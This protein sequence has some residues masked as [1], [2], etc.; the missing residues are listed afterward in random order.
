MT[1]ATLPATNSDFK[2]A[3][4][5]LQSKDIIGSLERE[6]S[7]GLES[8]S[9][10]DKPQGSFAPSL[11]IALSPPST[12]CNSVDHESSTTSIVTLND[13]LSH[14]L[15]KPSSQLSVSPKI[16]STKQL[17]LH[18]QLSSPTLS[19]SDSCSKSI[20]ATPCGL[21]GTYSNGYTGCFEGP[22]KLLEIWFDQKLLPPTSF[23]LRSIPRPELEAMLSLVHCSILD[24]F[25][26]DHL[27]SY[28]LSESSMFVFPSKIILKT[29]GTTTLLLALTQILTLANKYCGFHSIS[30]IFYSRKSFMF[31]DKQP[32]PHNSWANEV[33][34]L[35]SYFDGGKAYIIGDLSSEYWHLYVA[36]APTL[37]GLILN[38]SFQ[39]DHLSTPITLNSTPSSLSNISF[40]SAHS[41][42]TD[43]TVEILMTGLDQQKMKLMYCHYI[44]GAQEGLEGGKIVADECGLSSIYPGATASS[45]LFSPCG[46]SSNGLQ[47][48]NYF[49]VH[50][51]P[52]PSCSYASFESNIPLASISNNNSNTSTQVAL[53]QLVNQVIDIFLPKC[54]T[55]TVFYTANLLEQN[56]VP[57]SDQNNPDICLPYTFKDFCIT[58]TPNSY[59][60]ADNILYE[61]DDYHL[62]YYHFIQK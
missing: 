58:D 14:K 56:I 41:N 26:N 45:Y 7:K 46:L 44:Q 4:D 3:D 17:A 35:D 59:K 25:S 53:N 50:I 1:L 28:L 39:K 48:N 9:N 42:N 2:N 30:K 15:C 19:E 38:D 57:S 16:T 8:L 21:N 29:C 61:I 24:F 49:T 20:S 62:R 33:D 5:V 10:A 55:V 31:P 18:D 51:T 40:N 36:T 22:E 60:P 6:N 23:G 43:I 54:F 47:N 37:K 12:S 27:D 52:E 34:Y 13:N 11:S 32:I